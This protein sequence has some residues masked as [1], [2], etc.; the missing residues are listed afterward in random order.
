M[1]VVEMSP[2]GASQEAG[3][4]ACRDALRASLSHVGQGSRGYGRVVSGW[5]GQSPLVRADAELVVANTYSPILRADNANCP[6]DRVLTNALIAAYLPGLQKK[7]TQ[8]VVS[9]STPPNYHPHSEIQ[10]PQSKFQNRNTLSP[11]PPTIK[12]NPSSST[13]CWHPRSWAGLVEI[14]VILSPSTPA[15]RPCF[16]LVQKTKKARRL[17]SSR[18]A[19]WM[20]LQPYRYR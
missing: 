1:A 13:P 3:S 8:R 4:V 7:T 5:H 2:P 6:P 10:N 14:G 16:P 17:L 19:V 9:T 20:S 15:G 11:S 12:P 18:Q